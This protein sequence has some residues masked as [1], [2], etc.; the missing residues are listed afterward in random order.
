MDDGLGRTGPLWEGRRIIP[1]CGVVDL[2][3][4][5][6]EESGS[7][8]ARVRLELRLDVDDKCGSDGREQTGLS[9]S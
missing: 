6:T 3:D 5:D 1:E 8:V 2:V 4:E 7:L 9:L